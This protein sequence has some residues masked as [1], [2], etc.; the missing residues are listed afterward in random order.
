[1]CPHDSCLLIKL[2]PRLQ[3]S[4]LCTRHA[5]PEKPDI[6]RCK[7][8]VERLTSARLLNLSVETHCDPVFLQVKIE[9]LCHLSDAKSLA[10]DARYRVK[11]VYST[12]L[13]PWNRQPPSLDIMP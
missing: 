6:G 7:E 3:A 5:L 2:L 8:Q 11:S 1:M 9:A 13:A 10:A 4:F 12:S